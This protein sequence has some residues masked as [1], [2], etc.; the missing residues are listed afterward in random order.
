[1]Q[2]KLSQEFLLTVVLFPYAWFSH[3]RQ[4]NF[5]KIFHKFRCLSPLASVNY[6]EDYM[7]TSTV[8]ANT[9]SRERLWVCNMYHQPTHCK[10]KMPKIG[11]KYSQ[12]R[13]I[14]ASVPISTFMCLWAN[15]IFPRWVCLFCWMKYVDWSWEYINCSQTHECGNWIWG[16][17]IPRKGIYKR[18]C[19]C[20]AA[21][22]NL[23]CPKK[24]VLL[25]FKS[26]WSLASL[27]PAR[28]EKITLRYLPCCAFE[29]RPCINSWKN[30]I[31]FDQNWFSPF[32]F[33]KKTRNLEKF[34]PGKCLSRPAI[35]FS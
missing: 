21:S 34:C 27:T 16:R 24:I 25:I 14:G 8:F 31:I 9:W 26:F 7:V 15:Y 35:I 11:N 22:S 32:L 5:F 28:T 18:N 2:G 4:L 6:S 1:M 12:K 33:F 23:P 10:D 20:S 3:F 30:E 29:V 13:N 19:R 17:A